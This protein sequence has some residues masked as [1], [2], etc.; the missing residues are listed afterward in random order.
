MAMFM[1]GDEMIGHFGDGNSGAN[2]YQSK[3]I[4][5]NAFNGEQVKSISCGSFHTLALTQS[6]RV[7]SW[8]GSNEYGQLG[9]GNI[10][11]TH[12][13]KLVELSENLYINKII[14]GESYSLMLSSEGDIY[15]CGLLGF[16]WCGVS[17]N[18]S[19]GPTW[20]PKKLSHF[21]KF[22]DIASRSDYDLCAVTSV[23]NIY[24]IFK[25]NAEKGAIELQ[26]TPFNSFQ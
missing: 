17:H 23:N 2:G 5:M 15:F 13:P 11:D 25:L 12:T 6:G 22:I 21:E 18:S 3:P 8:G 9:V 26:E 16:R 14:C 19:Y 4:K 10:Q 1:C 7:Y 20:A 24:Y